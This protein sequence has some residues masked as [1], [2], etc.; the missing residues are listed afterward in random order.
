MSLELNLSLS[1]KVSSSFVVIF[2]PTFEVP[3][4]G[5]DHKLTKSTRP[6]PGSLKL[7][8][9]ISTNLKSHTLNP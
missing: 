8:N 9:F 4:K 1:L 2:S 7:I 3:F 6:K 5:K